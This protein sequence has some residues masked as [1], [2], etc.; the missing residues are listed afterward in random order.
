M[1]DK[2]TATSSRDSE[3]T[4]PHRVPNIIVGFGR[5]SN[6]LTTA[7]RGRERRVISIIRARGIPQG[8]VDRRHETL[9]LR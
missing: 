5:D 9:G 4:R 6:P 8:L 3:L 2:T 7:C 1:N